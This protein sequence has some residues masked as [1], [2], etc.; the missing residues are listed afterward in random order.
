MSESPGPL[1]SGELARS[2]QTHPVVVRRVLGHLR[3][4]GFVRSEKGHGGGWSISGDLD[5]LT[6][7]DIYEALG[8]PQ[9]F[10]IQNKNETP[11]C[12]IEQAVNAALDGPMRE[13]EAML[14][15]RMGGVSLS[16]IAQDFHRR[17]EALGLGPYDAARGGPASGEGGRRNGRTEPKGALR[18]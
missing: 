7:R 4:R 1:T 10:A 3:E 5:S 9:L 14:L 18:D 13:A 2:M 16:N 15:E 11:T 8:A 6:L 12:L 17:F